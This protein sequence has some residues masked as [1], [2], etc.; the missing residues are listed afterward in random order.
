[1]KFMLDVKLPSEAP[2]SKLPTPSTPG[3]DDKGKDAERG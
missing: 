2:G 3:H 1:M